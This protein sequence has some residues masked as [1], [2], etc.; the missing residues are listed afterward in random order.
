MASFGSANSRPVAVGNAEPVRS[1]NTCWII[2]EYVPLSTLI[3]KC[4]N[5][6]EFVD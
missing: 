4:T 2:L 5:E 1:D 6:F 3:V